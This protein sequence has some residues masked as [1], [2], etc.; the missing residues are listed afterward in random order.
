[1]KL[2]LISILLFVL[3]I[4]NP[5]IQ[6]Q[7][8]SDFKRSNYELKIELPRYTYRKYE[9]VIL[10]TEMINNDSIPLE[11]WGNFESPFYLADVVIT[12][13]QGNIFCVNQSH[14]QKIDAFLLAPTNIIL[15]GDTLFLSMSI[16]D[17]GK[18]ARFVS[19]K[20][21]DIYFANRGYFEKG[22]YIANITT[23]V[24]TNSELNIRGKIK[25]DSDFRQDN[26]VEIK[27]NDVNF[28][29][30]E[31]NDTDR[32]ILNQFK[33]ADFLYNLKPYKDV[34]DEFPD[35]AFTEI[36]Y[37]YYLGGKY[38]NYYSDK[39]YKY[40]NDLINDYENFIWKYPNSLYLLNSRIVEPYIYNYFID[41]KTNVLKEDFEQIYS[42]FK[43][44]N[45]YNMLKFFL[46]NK[47]R[48]KM[49]LH[50]M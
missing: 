25:S 27:S 11:L 21:N 38:L 44:Q 42:D 48:V 4:I 17:W 41:I 14:P 36:M 6:S 30:V 31:L 33:E 49:I 46:K 9:P 28:E 16:N 2:K 23:R 7:D 40:I 3:F 26:Q 37:I 13:E 47:R 43:S 45:E 29:V 32:V 22:K 10:K 12:D 15:P 5:C 1:M 19:Q 50:L 8:S 24:N 20:D 18:E 35:N 34:I 39:N